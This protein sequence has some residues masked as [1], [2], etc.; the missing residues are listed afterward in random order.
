MADLIE[1][2]EFYKMKMDEIE[3]DKI[4]EKVIYIKY[5]MMRFTAFPKIQ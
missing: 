2:M 3:E 5:H 1:L 4:D